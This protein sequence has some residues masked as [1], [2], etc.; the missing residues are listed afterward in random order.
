[1]IDDDQKRKEETSR[2]EAAEAYRYVRPKSAIAPAF[3]TLDIS[4]DEIEATNR[5][6]DA[7]LAAVKARFSL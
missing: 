6:R 4:P 3:Q 7:T 5:K 2:E 1:M